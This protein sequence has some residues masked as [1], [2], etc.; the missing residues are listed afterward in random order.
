MDD[1]KKNVQR[2]LLND[3][4]HLR[5]LLKTYLEKYIYINLNI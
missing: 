1:T 3:A 5:Q 4:T 2:K